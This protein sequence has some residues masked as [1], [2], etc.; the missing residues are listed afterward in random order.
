MTKEEQALALRAQLAT[1]D[2]TGAGKPF[3]DRLRREVVQ[4]ARA[5]MSEGES[6]EGVARD[7]GISA[8]SVKRWFERIGSR[9]SGAAELRRVEI[10]PDRREAGMVLA[11]APLVVHGPSGLRIEGLTLP[12]LVQLLRA[13]G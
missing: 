1:A 8:M 2:R 6:I 10:V 3:P 7:L 9:Y 11:A 13:L 12:G 5:A 4:Y